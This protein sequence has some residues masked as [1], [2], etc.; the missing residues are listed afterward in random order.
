MGWRELLGRALE[1]WKYDANVRVDRDTAMWRS[2]WEFA[3]EVSPF[4]SE[5]GVDCAKTRLC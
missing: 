1:P 3:I 2:D 5:S 4:Q